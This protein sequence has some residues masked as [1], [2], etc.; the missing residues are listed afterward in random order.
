MP[1]TENRRLPDEGKA[2]TFISE[3]DADQWHAHG[4]ATPAH[5]ECVEITPLV[6][7]ALTLYMRRMSALE[8]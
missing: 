1:L 5:L 7:A 4:A 6:A 3:E 2:I 8:P